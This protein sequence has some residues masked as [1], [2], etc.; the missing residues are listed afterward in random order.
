MNQKLIF[1]IFLVILSTSTLAQETIPPPEMV[2]TDE[3]APREF[4][5][6]EFPN[7]HELIVYIL[8]PVTLLLIHSILILKRWKKM[9]ILNKI[10]KLIIFGVGL[11]LVIQSIY[12][13]IITNR[14]W[15]GAILG[16]IMFGFF[17]LVLFLWFIEYWLSKKRRVLEKQKD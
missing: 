5:K 1:F 10:F 17:G 11:L 2:P 8:L 16:P 6:Y 15:E 7:F 12:L 4:V 9:I 13:G 14:V 3:P